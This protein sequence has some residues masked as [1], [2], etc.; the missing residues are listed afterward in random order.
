MQTQET[1]NKMPDV[2]NSYTKNFPSYIFI[3]SVVFI[4]IYIFLTIYTGSPVY[5]MGEEEVPKTVA[6][7]SS[8][9]M[10]INN[11]VAAAWIAA[12]G[13]VV[14]T[15]TAPPSVKMKL[16]GGGT[17]GGLAAL[18]LANKA[19]VPQNWVQ[20]KA[21]VQTG[22]TGHTEDTV[23]PL[24]MDSVKKQSM[25]PLVFDFFEM[26][27][28]LF[29]YFPSLKTILLDRL[30]DECPENIL[31]TYQS[32]FTQYN[33]MVLIS[34]FSLFIIVYL[35]TIIYCLMFLK[36]NKAYLLVNYPNSLGKVAN[37]RYT[38][39]YIILLTLSVYLNFIVIGQCLYF[40]FVNYIP[41][42]IGNIT[43]MALLNNNM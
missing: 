3:Y 19:S 40:M 22:F 10:G 6:E 30:P 20:M 18:H 39:Y 36:M 16:L 4:V 23:N 17:V 43:D 7:N 14:A 1:T 11:N 32:L 9:F 26:I 35:Y 15:F 5:C 13:A 34:L 2:S 42:N 31:I 25:I 21:M 41:S 38:D 37:S 12:T 33:I 29:S 27:N 28:S 8:T 24:N